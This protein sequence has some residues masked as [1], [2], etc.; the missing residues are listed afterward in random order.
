[1]TK[2]I[3]ARPDVSVLAPSASSSKKRK[4]ESAGNSTAS[5]K[6]KNGASG[7]KL[8][9]ANKASKRPTKAHTKPLAVPKKQ[10]STGAQRSSD[11]QEEVN[12][13]KTRQSSR[14]KN[15]TPMKYGGASDADDFDDFMNPRVEADGESE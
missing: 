11:G 7:S 4:L 2:P 6:A 12:I 1:M 5:K 15:L 13:P 14:I 9:K 3:G 10:G 8:S